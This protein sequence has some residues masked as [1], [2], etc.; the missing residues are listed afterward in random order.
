MVWGHGVV[1]EGQ[2]GWSCVFSGG[3]GRGSLKEEV[4]FPGVGELKVLLKV[5]R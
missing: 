2:D 4:I 1:R 5:V 3:A